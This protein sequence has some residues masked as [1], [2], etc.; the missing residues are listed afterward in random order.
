MTTDNGSQPS[1]ENG[2]APV[3]WTPPGT[4]PTKLEAH[5]QAGQLDALSRSVIAPR[6]DVQRSSADMFTWF[7]LGPSDSGIVP[8]GQNT[9]LRDKQLRDFITEEHFFASALG[10]IAARNAALTWQITGD[11]ASAEASA[12][13]INDANHGEGWESF[14][15]E[16]SN[17]LLTQDKGA[18]VE[19]VRAANSPDA[20]V[21]GINALDAQRCFLTGNPETPVIYEDRKGEL[22]KMPWYTVVHMLEMPTSKTPADGGY[23]FR[24]Q[25][26]ALTRV[27]GAAQILKSITQY[28]SEKVSGRFMRAIHLVSGVDTKA[29]QDAI[30]RENINADNAGA[31]RYMAPAMVG[32]V[33]PAANVSHETIELA[34]LPDGF[35]EVEAVTTY[36][37]ILAM[38]F[39]TDYQ[40]FAPLSSGNLG[41]ST[42][43]EVLHQKSRGKGVGLFK[44]LLERLMNLR[45]ALPANVTFEFTEDDIE[46]DKQIADTGLVRAETRK[47]RIESGEID[48][49][50]ARQLALDSGDLS[51]EEFEALNKREI[52][53]AAS[54]E[55]AADELGELT[56][57]DF[58][59]GEQ[60][61]PGDITPSVTVEDTTEGVKG[62]ITV[63]PDS[64]S[65]VKEVAFGQALVEGLSAGMDETDPTA[66]GALGVFVAELEAEGIWD[67]MVPVADIG[68]VVE[69]ATK[70]MAIGFRAAIDDEPQRRAGPTEDRLEFEA[71]VGEDIAAGLGAI[72]R[73]IATRLREA[74]PV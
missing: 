30:G 12:E 59:G 54:E 44:K 61:P 29:I 72:R 26:S 22:H 64:A 58:G 1:D 14:V 53:E 13:L 51:V 43:S 4:R 10:I 35:S 49:L 52:A 5:K 60:P 39:L 62:P 18:F 23:F 42:Q 7:M 20:A 74:A 33:D 34:S 3:I 28:R 70:E 6:E 57:L 55:E 40:E 67:T 32:N 9:Q 2:A 73:R 41:N 21:I 45:G 24:L 15:V 31:T 65:V 11:E 17:D 56:G 63:T 19:F 69:R 50:A 47:I 37:T 38:G 27:L 25:Y 68:R 16:L 46:A 36:I 66:V 8:W 71:E 48:P